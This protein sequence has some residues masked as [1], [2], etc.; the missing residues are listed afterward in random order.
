MARCSDHNITKHRN[1]RYYIR[2]WANGVEHRRSA[3]TTS[4]AEAKRFRDL[5]LGQRGAARRIHAIYTAQA[6]HGAEFPEIEKWASVVLSGARSR[7]KKKGMACTITERDVTDLLS[8]T[9]GRCQL[10]GVPLLFDKRTTFARA[11]PFQP[12][13]DRINSRGGY[14]PG[15]VRIVCFAANIALGQW[16]EGVFREPCLG[17]IRTALDRLGA[18]ASS[19]AELLTTDAQERRAS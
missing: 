14:E 1:G 2:Y 6:E 4:L 18:V 16:G 15:N 7:A 19:P 3:G 11:N 9:G 10:T 8:A 13:L 12:S 17:Y 5:L